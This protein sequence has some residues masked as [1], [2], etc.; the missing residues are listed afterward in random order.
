MKT[1]CYYAVFER[2]SIQA[3]NA[4]SGP[5][6]Y[7]FPALNGFL[8]AMHALNRKLSATGMPASLGGVLIANHRCDI[9][10]FQADIFSDAVFIQSR[11]PIKRNGETAPI[12]EEGKVHL[13]VSL[14]VEVFGH[15]ND[16]QPQAN[17]LAEQLAKL[18]YQQRIAG[19]SVTRIG[20]CR[21][22]PTHQSADVRRRLLPGFVLMN[23]DRKLKIITAEL[24]SGICHKYSRGRLKAEDGEDGEPIPTGMPANPDA[25]QL[26][27]LLATAMRYHQ[28]QANGEWHSTGIKSRHG[29]IV[30]L[31]LGYQA[32]SP[33]FP[34]GKMQHSR[35]PDYPAC[36]AEALYGLGEWV[37][38]TR[39]PE[40][41]AGCFWRY[42]EP[43]EN[44]YLITQSTDEQGEHYV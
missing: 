31:P 26:D 5:L 28:P 33:L 16:I 32:I 35:N 19:G 14:A 36:Y 1:P 27:A 21:L 8:G 23:A 40:T 30:P 38:P 41:L 37:F 12:I 13:T 7:G 44:L 15:I 3:A 4:V 17:E 11:N 22:Y 18:L 42:A 34:A 10:A 20:R 25:S 24:K 29:W 6:S 2:V 43:Q 9:Q 39:L